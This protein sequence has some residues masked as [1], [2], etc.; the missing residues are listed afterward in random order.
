MIFAATTLTDPTGSPLSK[1]RWLWWSYREGKKVP[2]GKS[3]D[4]RTWTSRRDARGG[5]G[6]GFVLGHVAEEG[7]YICG[8]DLDG[9]LDGDEVTDELSRQVLAQF[10]TYCEVSPSGG[11]LHLL[12]TVTREDVQALGLRSTTITNTGDHHGVV[13]DIEGR[14]YAVTDDYYEGKRHIR[15][16]T[17]QQL[18]WLL[19]Q[20][21][22]PT[23]K[24][25]DESG[26]GY[27]DR[28]FMSY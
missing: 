25:R 4:P 28:F 5:D 7:E 20:K 19:A 18:G 3:N 22:T 21:V 1:R 12:F 16:A 2:N 9:C 23:G 6:V 27:G 10:N 24:A 17:R 15:Q 26:S 8:I 11:G 13:L 14:Y